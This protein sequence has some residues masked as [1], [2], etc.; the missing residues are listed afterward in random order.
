M[1][2]ITISD[3][4]LY[5]HSTVPIEEV[6]CVEILMPQDRLEELENLLKWYEDKETHSKNYEDVLKQL[7]A[8][9]RVRIENPV[10][11][12]AYQKYKNLLELCRR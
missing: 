8:D 7:R 9:E 11:L 4:M 10:V 12:K 5:Q 3:E 2:D 1:W 6:D